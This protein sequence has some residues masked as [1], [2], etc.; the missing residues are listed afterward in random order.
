MIVILA[1]D[2]L[3]YRL[4]EKFNCTHLKQQFYGKT[5]ISVFSAPRT[6]VL[7]SSFLATVNKEQE[8]LAKGD[9]EM[10]NT[11]IPLADTFFRHFRNPNII[12]LP[13]F[14]YD[15]QQHATERGLLKSFFDTNDEEQR[16]QILQQYN[17]HAFAH[18]RKIKRDFAEALLG[19]Y[20]VVLGYFSVADVIGHLNFGNTTMMKM[21]YQDLDELA[22]KIKS[23]KLLVLSDHGME[24]IGKYGDHSTYGFWSTNFRELGTPQITDFGKIII[25]ATT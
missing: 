5:N 19:D 23:D 24:P 15:K 11:A 2:A 22:A 12:D 14:N 17:N 21:I 7:W 3:E 6:M 25:E 9:Q 10:W 13:G 4:V 20:D 18:H 1:I 16:R 8:I